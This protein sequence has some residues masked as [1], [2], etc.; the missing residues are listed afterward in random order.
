MARAKDVFFIQIASRSFA[1]TLASVLLNLSVVEVDITKTA[2]TANLALSG[3]Y[4]GQPRA[5]IRERVRTHCQKSSPVAPQ[6]RAGNIFGGNYPHIPSG[7]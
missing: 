2:H 3:G 4:T 6:R 1:V 5:A 7:L